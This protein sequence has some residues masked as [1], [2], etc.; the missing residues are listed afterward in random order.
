MRH[1]RQPGMSQSP[2]LRLAQTQET[3]HDQK[4]VG[5]A[6]TCLAAAPEPRAVPKFLYCS[7]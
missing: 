7:Y 5:S 4:A 1:E 3:Q 6:T 2:P